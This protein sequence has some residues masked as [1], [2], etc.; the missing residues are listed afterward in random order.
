LLQVSLADRAGETKSG[1]NSGQNQQ[2]RMVAG[3]PVHVVIH[4]P[5]MK[6]AGERSERELA[7]VPVTSRMQYQ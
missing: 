7:L 1:E 5:C 2:T 6:V 3:I 4:T